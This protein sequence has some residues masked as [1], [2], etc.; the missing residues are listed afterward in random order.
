MRPGGERVTLSRGSLAR[1]VVFCLVLGA[2]VGLLLRA[3]LGSDGYSTFV[4]G[5]ALSLGV[6]FVAVNGVVGLVLVIVAWARGIRPGPGTV[7]QPV[8][9]GATVSA[10]LEFVP[11]LHAAPVR[12]AAVLAG[13][14]IVALGV[15]GY[16]ASGAG[17]GP[18]EAAALAFDPPIPFRWSYSILQGGGALVGWLLGAALGPGT[19]LVIVGLGPAVDVITRWVATARVPVATS[20]TAGSCQ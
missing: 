20:S 17:A 6:P 10:V 12:I 4:N 2:G 14:V 13:F 19:V 11:P 16:L 8:V 7:V 18:T 3:A 1:L 5:L 15:A 9:V